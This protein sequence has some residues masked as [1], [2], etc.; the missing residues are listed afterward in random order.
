[1][2]PDFGTCSDCRYDSFATGGGKGCISCAGAE[3]CTICSAMGSF[4]DVSA[5]SVKGM[6]EDDV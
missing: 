2:R 4:F 5:G 1:M 6:I 3:D